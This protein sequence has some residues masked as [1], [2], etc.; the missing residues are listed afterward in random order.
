NRFAHRPQLDLSGASRASIARYPAWD[1]VGG[2]TVE[3][4]ILGPVTACEAG[5]PVPLGGV[6][7][8]A[9][10]A[11]L[12]VGAGRV[13][14]AAELAGI[15]WEEPPATA[16]QQLRTMVH[17][18]RQ[19]MP[20]VSVRTVPAGYQLDLDGHELDAERFGAGI[21]LAR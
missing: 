16:R 3:F 6:R 7:R 19:V 10:L 14:S 2:H 8:H 21:A 15:A 20:T 18:L 1:V 9:V 17:R 11:G 12:L 13:V 4:G 5:R